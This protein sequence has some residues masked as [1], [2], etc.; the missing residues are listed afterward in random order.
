MTPKGPSGSGRPARIETVL[1]DAGGVLIDLDY[2]LLRLADS[3]HTEGFF[4]R[5]SS[6]ARQVLPPRPKPAPVVDEPDPQLR[7]PGL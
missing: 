3:F 1:L 7:L 6:L 5:E 2:D 4:R